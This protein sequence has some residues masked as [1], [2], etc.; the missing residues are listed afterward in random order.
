MLFSHKYGCVAH[1]LT[2]MLNVIPLKNSRLMK[3]VLQYHLASFKLIQCEHNV[4]WHKKS[5]GASACDILTDLCIVLYWFEDKQ[6]EITPSW[7]GLY[8]TR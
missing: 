3:I 8:V 4:V 6:M 2:L 5:K 7:S 1:T